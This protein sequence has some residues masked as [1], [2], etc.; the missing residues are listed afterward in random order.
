MSFSIRKLHVKLA[1]RLRPA[2][3]RLI[4]GVERSI[5]VQKQ[6]KFSPF[7]VGITG[8]CGK[9]TATKLL[10]ELLAQAYGEDVY[11]GLG[12]NTQHWAYR[13][14]CKLD[15]DN[16]TWVQE[17]SGAEPGYLDYVVEDIPLDV[18]ILTT[19]GGDH[20]S[21]FGNEK[22]ILEEKSKLVAAL[23]ADGVACLN[24]DDRLLES[25]ATENEN[26]KSI[27][28]YGVHKDA[29][30]RAEIKTADWKNRLQF[31]LFVGEE[32]FDVVTKFVG[33]LLLSSILAALAA[34]KAKGLPLGPAVKELANLEPMTNHMSLEQTS[35][36]QSYLMDAFKATYWATKLFAED[37]VR[38]KN[39]RLVLV[40]GQVSDTGNTGSRAYRQIIR[41]AAPHCDIIIGMDG[42]FRAAQKLKDEFDCCA[43]VPSDNLNEVQSLLAENRD[44]LIVI[45]AGRRSKLWRLWEMANA[46]I[47]CFMLPCDIETSCPD[48]PKLRD[49]S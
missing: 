19:I 47:N 10:S 49:K 31:K 39:G 33:S 7:K 46:P 21:A 13:G 37:L 38:I 5:A 45:K 20:I 32:Q 35:S 6:D 26:K 1:E 3:F 22:A 25:F 18:A 48:C 24:I 4:R 44:G 41:A 29:D 16:R 12:Y 36:G 42:A 11:M 15:R 27:I 8:S 40:L 43:I 30:V 9:S 34:I 2:Y 28:T 23:K 17:I 14:L